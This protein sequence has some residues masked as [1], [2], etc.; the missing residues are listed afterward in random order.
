MTMGSQPLPHPLNRA[1]E[2]LA[3]G[4]SFHCR[5]AL[6]VSFPAIFKSQEIKPSIIPPAVPAKTNHLRLLRGYFQSVL[7]QALLECSLKCRRFVP[8]LETRHKVVRKAEQPAL[9]S[10]RFAHCLL[11]PQ[12]QDVVRYT[13]ANT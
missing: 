2:F 8:I 11:K 6:S 13:L 5:A 1:L 12:V 10:I 9:S 4:P 3:R 7:R